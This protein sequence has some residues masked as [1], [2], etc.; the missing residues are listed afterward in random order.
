MARG[1]LVVAVTNWFHE[2]DPDP[3]RPSRG[4]LADLALDAGDAAEALERLTDAVRTDRFNGFQVFVADPESAHVLHHPGNG[5]FSVEAVPDGFHILTN[6][7]T[8]NAFD[9]DGALDVADLPV[10]CSINDASTAFSS[11]LSVHDDRGPAG[12]DAICKHSE[13]R[14]T[15]SS[16][17]LAV[18][19]TASDA[20]FLFAAGPPCRTDFGVY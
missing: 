11:A 8:L 9:H 19:A 3:S 10:G 2:P 5:G 7:W 18:G 20:R 4:V 16:A 12:P 17:I 13:S 15:L 1:S 6:C 14:G